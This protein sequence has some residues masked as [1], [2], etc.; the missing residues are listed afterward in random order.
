[1]ASLGSTTIPF[2]LIETSP[3]LS[4][5][6]PAAAVSYCVTIIISDH[7]LTRS[8]NFISFLKSRLDLHPYTA[9]PIWSI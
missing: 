5:Q 6:T 8:L 3:F 9:M 7:L 1:M 2:Q 4:L